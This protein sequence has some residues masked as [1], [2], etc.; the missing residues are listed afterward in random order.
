MHYQLV[1]ESFGREEKLQA[2]LAE[3]STIGHV[4]FKEPAET[5]LQFFAI[6]VWE[7]QFPEKKLG[8]GICYQA[9]GPK[10]CFLLQRELSRLIIGYN[11][12][13][14]SVQLLS[15]KSSLIMDL[16]GIIYSI[17][18]MEDFIIIVYETGVVAVTS[19]DKVLWHFSG[20]IIESFTINDGIGYMTYMEGSDPIRLNLVN[21]R[22]VKI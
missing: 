7:K 20:D 21:G 15:G 5:K 3:S 8:V 9:H 22:I 16:D 6:L 13:V 4:L 17:I 2:F 18:Q 12:T 14:R 10:P 19:S 1:T 11:R